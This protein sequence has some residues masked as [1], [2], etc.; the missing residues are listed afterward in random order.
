M[1]RVNSLY[2]YSK[3][4]KKETLI[5]TRTIRLFINLLSTKS[6]LTLNSMQQKLIAVFHYNIDTSLRGKCDVFKVVD[7]HKLSLSL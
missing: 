4:L 3:F 1:P 5:P 6:N 2:I 7:F